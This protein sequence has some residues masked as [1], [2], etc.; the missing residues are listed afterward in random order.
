MIYF[1][2]AAT[3]RTKPEVV[4][5]AYNFYLREIG[6]SPGRGSYTL[7]IQASRMLYQARKN[8]ILQILQMSYSQKILLKQLT[9][10]FM[11]F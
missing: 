2:N 5:E 6:T 10:F 3:S 11:D 9:C 8:S 4:Y 7:A 1:D